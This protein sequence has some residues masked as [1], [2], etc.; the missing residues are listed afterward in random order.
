MGRRGSAIKVE[1]RFVPADIGP[2]LD[3]L[4]EHIENNC[5]QLA[6]ECAETAKGL[7]GEKT[8]YLKKHI[9]AYRSRYEE[10]GAICYADA[11]HAWLVEFGHALIRNG[12]VIGHVPAHPFMRPA[13]EKVMARARQLFG[14]L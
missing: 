11:P 4:N 13:K 1:A 6:Q 7:V 5:M 9:K 8:G 10:G 3:K 12:Q 2:I 14:V